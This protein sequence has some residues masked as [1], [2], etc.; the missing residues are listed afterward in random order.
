MAQ[1]RRR[2]GYRWLHILLRREGIGLNRKKP[3]RLYRE[4]ALTAKEAWWPQA[5]AGDTSPLA[6]PQGADQRW[7]LDFVSDALADGARSRVLESG[8]IDGIPLSIGM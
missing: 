1:Q 3:F 7:S 5:G 6:L 4:E 8:P 2:F